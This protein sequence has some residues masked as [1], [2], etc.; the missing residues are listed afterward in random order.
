MANAAA[1]RRSHRAVR[2]TIDNY[3]LARKTAAHEGETITCWLCNQPIDMTI[4]DPYDDEV[5]EPDH[6]YPGADYPE[7]AA[8]PDNL[9][10]SHRGCNRERGNAMESTNVGWN[11]I[12]WEHIHEDDDEPI[13]QD[14][15]ED[16]EPELMYAA[17]PRNMVVGSDGYPDL[18]YTW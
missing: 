2:A 11:S 7:L 15:T 9:R 18:D 1:T 4:V 6:V 13:E 5:F 16:E 14:Q 3:R 12:D 17:E 10:D 8:D